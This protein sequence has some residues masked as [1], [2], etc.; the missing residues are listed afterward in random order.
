M[1]LFK[2]LKLNI[3]LQSDKIALH[4]EVI[5]NTASKIEK[6]SKELSTLYKE[7]F[8]NIRRANLRKRHLQKYIKELEELFPSQEL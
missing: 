2:S 7:P 5:A 3:M 8:F 1:R 4:Y 6:V